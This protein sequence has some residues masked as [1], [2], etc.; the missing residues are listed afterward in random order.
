MSFLNKSFSKFGVYCGCIAVSVILKSKP[1]TFILWYV[2]HFMSEAAERYPR[3]IYRLTE[4]QLAA[5][6]TDHASHPQ[7]SY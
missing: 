5:K 4:L 7:L 6:H 1:K 2:L 3:T